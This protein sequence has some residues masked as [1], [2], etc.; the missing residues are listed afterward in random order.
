LTDVAAAYLVIATTIFLSNRHR[1]NT[2]VALAQLEML[3][4]RYS[5]AH[6]CYAETPTPKWTRAK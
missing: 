1:Q 3:H 6:Y 4:L 2:S 5:L